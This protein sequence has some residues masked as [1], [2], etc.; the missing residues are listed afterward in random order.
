MGRSFVAQGFIHTVHRDGQW[1]NE[2]E[3][4]GPIRGKHERKTEAVE[5]GRAR[6]KRDKIEHVIHN[7]DGK[8]SGRNSY[9][10]DPR[11]RRG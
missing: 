2:I 5:A 11:R 3:G 1:L 6:A 7:R 8:I 9:G 10:S 4:K